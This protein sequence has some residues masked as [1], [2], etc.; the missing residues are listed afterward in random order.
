ME[1]P[2]NLDAAVW[3]QMDSQTRRAVHGAMAAEASAARLEGEKAGEQKA[4][5]RHREM[6]LTAIC[7]SS[8]V[9]VESLAHALERFPAAAQA[10]DAWGERALAALCRN[11]NATP[12]VLEWLLAHGASASAGSRDNVHRS[13]ALHDLARRASLVRTTKWF[14]SVHKRAHRPLVWQSIHCTYAYCP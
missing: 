4:N 13:T 11:P 7:G 1:C 2:R 3:A 12:V 9:S 10:K 5:Q 14:W 6:S 8:D